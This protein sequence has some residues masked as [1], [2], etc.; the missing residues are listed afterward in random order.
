MNRNTAL[1]VAIVG[2]LTLLACGGGYTIWQAGI[3][4]DAMAAHAEYNEAM[5]LTKVNQQLVTDTYHAITMADA[6]IAARQ[7]D[8]DGRA[9]LKKSRDGI[10]ATRA[11]AEEIGKKEFERASGLKH[12]WNAR[13][14]RLGLDLVPLYN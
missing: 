10:A 13:W 12:K 8:P 6:M 2:L 9:D 14:Q 4:R 1:L 3:D 5:R 11:K 7:N